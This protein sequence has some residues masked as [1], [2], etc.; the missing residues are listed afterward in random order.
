MLA[1]FDAPFFLDSSTG[2]RLHVYGA[3]PAAPR[4]ILVL[5]H[6]M[7]EHAGRYRR[8]ARAAADHGIA[9]YA[10]DHRGHGST[11]APDARLGIFA[12]RDGWKAII[13]DVMAVRAEALRR[14][15]GLPVVLM[16]H[17]MG[18]LL[19]LNAVISHPHDFAA[20]AVW[21]ANFKAGV[22][23]RAAQAILAVEK[24]L[25]G[26]DVPSTIIPRLTFEA[27]AKQVPDAD[28]EFDWLSHDRAQVAAYV[29]DPRCGF[30]ASVSMW[31]DI[32]RLIFR[33][34]DAKNWRDIPRDLPI[35]LLGGAD[36]PST[37][38]GEALRWLAG[39]LRQA[40]FTHVDLRIEP[41]MRHE[42]LNEIGAE[43]PTADLM[44]WID[45]AVDSQKDEKKDSPRP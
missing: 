18:G 2:A 19:A 4:A 42:T 29:D 21:N 10:A 9:F 39:R 44:R 7:V 12:A 8:L 13:E 41:G 43:R 17:S 36:D 40:G 6:G 38:N 16:G 24:A 25:K 3:A 45:R 34:G 1:S 20:L 22:A 27:W 33:G 11:E 26:S 35:D 5:A 31:I 32:F 28:T 23:G 15:P 37:E 14:H 30:D